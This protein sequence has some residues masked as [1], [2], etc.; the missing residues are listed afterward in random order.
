M[1]GSEL[2]STGTVT[3]VT[4][5]VTGIVVPVDPGLVVSGALTP[6]SLAANLQFP[7]VA[8]RARTGQPG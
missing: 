3:Q 5:L 2:A 7:R 8:P 6:A 4:V 1:P